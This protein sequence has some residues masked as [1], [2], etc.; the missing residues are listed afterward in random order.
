MPSFELPPKKKGTPN[1]R[2]ED[3]RSMVIVGANGSGKS[4]MG[5]KIEQM[6][7]ANAHR[8]SAQRALTIPAYVQPRA[9]EQAEC[10]L[11]YGNYDPGQKPEQR[12][13]SKFGN[14]WGDEP[15]SRMLGDF[16]HVLALLFA[17]EAKRNRDYSRA[18][19]KTLPTDKPPKCKLDTLSEIWQTV[20]PQRKLTIFDDKIDAQTPEGK[21]YEARQMSD[22]ERV[23]VYLMGQSLCAP[24]GSIVIIDEPEI[25]LHRAI[26]AQLWD[27]IE[28]ARPDCTFIYITHDLDFAATRAGARKIWLKEFD[29]TDWVWE[30]VPAGPAMPDALMFQVLGSRRPLLF[31]EG[32]ETSYDSAIYTALYPK[33]LVVPRQSCDKVVEAAKSMS[34]LSAMHNLNVRGLVDRDRRGDEEIDALRADGILVADVAE[35]E[36]LLCLPEALEAVAKLLR[37]DDVAKAKGAAENAVIA[38]MAKVIDQ[39][40]L[41]RGL[42]EIQFR[43]NGFGPKI[44]KSDAAKLGTELQTYVVGI[45]V[46]VTVGKCR[47]LFED[48][49]AAKDYRATLRLYNCKGVIAFVATSLG[50]KK[51]VYC[52][53]VLDLVKTEPEGPV[54]KA[55]RKAIEGT[56]E[57]LVVTP[58]VLVTETTDV[59]APLA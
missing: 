32:D 24:S 31:V 34:G 5:A 13:A 43:L 12:A 44:G 19:L 41:A 29:G 20:M 33:E 18:A 50:I 49:A 21:T 22:G 57:P 55:M 37:A 53:M 4:R 51:D 30:E 8:L 59:T 56:P 3:V 38:E 35:V 54:A 7:G 45:D 14:R 58:P 28:A 6:A 52:R 46:T 48:A 36:N 11:L 15:A 23:T 40:A 1:V 10:T 27:K 26:Q 2:F 17:D 39:Q 42:A 16:E 25:H 9:Y 47:K